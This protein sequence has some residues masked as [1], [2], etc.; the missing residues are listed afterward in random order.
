[1][2]QEIKSGVVVTDANG[3][4]VTPRMLVDKNNAA[5]V[6][7]VN[8]D[9]SVKGGNAEAPTERDSRQILE[10]IL[11]TLQRMEMLMMSEIGEPDDAEDNTLQA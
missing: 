9:G 6:S 7:Q 10:D 1:M 8:E 2:S 11:A 5:R 3:N 4:Q